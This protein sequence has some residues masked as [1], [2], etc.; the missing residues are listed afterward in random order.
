MLGS[1]KGLASLVQF[2]GDSS[3]NALCEALR[4]FRTISRKGDTK[5]AEEKYKHLHSLIVDVTQKPWVPLCNA[6]LTAA[7]EEVTTGTSANPG[8]AKRLQQVFPIESP[9]RTT[10][11]AKYDMQCWLQGCLC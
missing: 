4:A 8:L 9:P 6:A 7:R 5:P 11:D 1:E 2:A 10:A 3:I